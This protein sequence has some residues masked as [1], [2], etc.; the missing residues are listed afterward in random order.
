MVDDDAS[1]TVRYLTGGVLVRVNRLTQQVQPELATEWKMSNGGKTVRFK[2]RSGVRYSD[3]S[4]FSSTDVAYTIQKL[5]DPELHSSTADAFRSGQ[6]NVRANVISPNVIDITFPAPVANLAALFDSVAILSST[7]PKK[8]MA[9]LGPFYV[10]E[11]KAGSYLLLNR[12]PNYWKKD[13]QGR[14]LPYVNSVRLEIEQNPEVEALRF[15]RGEI[16]LIN[17]VSP[18]VFEKLSVT[19]AGLVRDVGPSTDTEQLWF[20]QVASAPI[21]TY[22]RAWFSST[23]FRR[24]VSEAINRE[25][26]AR[27]V[28]RGHATAAVGNVPQSNRFWFNSSLQPHPYDASASLRFLQQDGFRFADGVLRDKNGNAV[29]FSIITNAGNRSRENMA[30]MIQQDLKK[31]GIKLNVVTLD[32]N[33]LLERM[34]QTYNYEACLLGTVNGDLDPSSQMT[35]WLS[36][37]EEHIWN[38]KQKVAATPWEA[39]IDLQMRAQ[40]SATDPLKRKAAW[41]RVQKIVWEQEPIIYLVNKDSLVAISP[42]VKNAQP[43]AFRPQTYWNV[44]QLGLAR[45]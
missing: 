10:A 4:A 42:M 32:F 39:A 6:G 2:L 28:F 24:A 21:P 16:D 37:G 27:L 9:A 7:S 29:E 43:S 45:Q 38:P 11:H 20:N 1:E 31:I 22:K 3:G 40:A 30:T 36:S 13:A 12:N 44:E 25:D 34:T 18:T 35:M 23:A 14:Q 41:D 5:M 15:Q 33:S 26:L 8:E 19:N 17:A